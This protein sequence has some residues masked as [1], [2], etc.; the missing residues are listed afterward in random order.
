MQEVPTLEIIISHVNT[1]FDALASMIAA[2]KLYPDAQVV[3]SDKQD[4]RVTRFLNMYRDVLNFKLDTEIDWANVSKIILVDVASLDRVGNINDQLKTNQVDFIVFDHH[5]PRPNNVKFIEGKID[6][7]GAAITLLLEEI[8]TKQ[9]P[10]S[11]FEATLFGLGLYTDTGNFTFQHTTERDLNMAAFLIKNGMNLESV[12]R[13]SEQV[14]ELDQQ[15]LLEQLREHADIKVLDGLDFVIS[16]ATTK[17]FVTGLSLLTHTLMQQKGVDVSITVVK[18]KNH[19]QIVGRTS[20]DR[21]NLLPLFKSF[22]GGGHQQACSA[23]VKNSE[24]LPVYEKVIEH[25]H[26]VLRPSITAEQIMSHPVK[27]LTPTTPIAEASR[28]MYRYGHSGY[29]IIENDQLV[30][31]ITRRDLDKG[32]HHGLGHAPVKAYMTTEVITIEKDTSFEDIQRLIINF[33]IGRL[34]VIDQGKLI[35]IVTRTNIIE[36]LHDESSLAMFNETSDHQKNHMDMLMKKQLPSSIYALL[37]HISQSAQQFSQPVYVVGGFV[38]DLLLK[39]SNDDIDLVV[40]G[41]GVAF[42]KQLQKDFGGDVLIHDQ[43]GTATWTHPSKVTIDI[44]SSR[45][46]YYERPASLPDVEQSTLQEDL[47]RRDFTINAMAIQLNEASF[48]ELIDPFSGQIDLE[49]KTIKVLH[50]MSFVEDPTRIFRGIRFEQRFK[51]SMDEQ[52]KKLALSSMDKV[53]ALSP[54]RIHDQ[55]E[56]L[57]N[58]GQP[59]SVTARLFDLQFWQQFGIE[60]KDKQKSCHMTKELERNFQQYL[61]GI[62]PNWFHYM[63]IP[64]YVS[65]QLERMMPFALIKQHKQFVD[66][67][68]HIEEKQLTIKSVESIG[69]Y[70]DNFHSYHDEVLL[71]IWTALNRKQ[72]DPFIHYL[73]A[74]KK[75]VHYFSGKDLINS[76]LKPGPHFSS[77]FLQL[78]KSQLNG[79]ITSQ[80]DANQWLN[81]YRQSHSI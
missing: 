41:N 33:N 9:L 75:L 64:F 38:R 76:G 12:Q 6:Q 11:E 24:L 62:K 79:D 30:G 27:S 54:N 73:Q 14:L 37:R 4:D 45:L 35:G 42:A 2:K 46:E 17:P 69:D 52:T 66:E 71:F 19:I 40:E 43:F 44:T 13:F 74:R 50:N 56:K 18:M 80:E 48:G 39:R 53:T 63:L 21:V 15:Q 10:I 28:L 51:F 61:S 58:E 77:L 78:E 8:Q 25:L 60:Q 70:H 5:P 20:S 47:E 59:T 3:L 72:N 34:P 68:L 31:V 57:Y 55:L 1:D 36:T 16:S 65:N 49:N 67:L 23:T 22:G 7:V 29:P 81:K 26:T 32:N